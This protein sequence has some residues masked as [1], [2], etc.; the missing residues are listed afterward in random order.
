MSLN[1]ALAGN[2]NSGKSTL[3]NS[4]TGG[5]AYVGNWPGVTIEKKVGSLKG[6]KDVKVVDLPGI[7]SLSPYSPEEIITRDYIENTKPDAIINVVDASNL[8]RNLYLTTQ[9][10][11]FGVPVIVAL[12]M[13]DVVEHRGDKIDISKLQSALGCKVVSLSALKGNGIE[14]LL[15]TTFKSAKKSKKF[16]P[17]AVLNIDD[18]EL[19]PE[20]RYAMIDKILSEVY[21]KNTNF[22]DITKKIDSVMLNKWLAFPIFIVIIFLIYYISV[23]TVGSIMTE[24]VGDVLFGEWIAS[25]ASWLLDSVG[26]GAWMGDLIQN[27]LIGGVG[28][29]IGFTPQLFLLFLILSFLEDSGYMARIAFV[30]DKVFRKFGLSGKSF[31][32]MI[33]S[34]GCGVPGIMSSRA[35]ENLSDRRITIMTATFIPCSAK[36]PIIVLLVSS[37]FGGNPLVAPSVYLISVIAILISALILKSTNRFKSENAPFLMELPQY[38]MPR[39]RNLF[40]HAWMKTK[41]F[42]LRAGTI[43]FVACIAIWFLSNCTWNL[44]PAS[45]TDSILYGIGNFIAPIFKP[46]G[47]G[48]WHA[49]MATLTGLIAKENLVGTL[50]TLGVD[51]STFFTHASAYAFIVFNS[52]CMPCFAAV[53]AMR[54]EL[55]SFKW[56]LFGVAYQTGFAYIF[57]FIVYRF[58]LA[59]GI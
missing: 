56:T 38:R 30:L 33:I 36:L 24:W 31:I 1:I 42:I 53:A 37:V 12:N 10:F 25:W 59:L 22:N 15:E 17:N 34:S 46:L 4:I 51:S 55:G 16:S 9:L 49:A 21:I 57:A 28:A 5:D 13:S 27:G 58:I 11:E 18:K 26:A 52:L 29:V 6:R 48:D 7:Y 44:A 47:F 23:T 2:P 35:I 20:F 41:D 39:I 43:I 3:F 8:E 45:E 40:K 50:E 32:P 19:E 54:R 14:K